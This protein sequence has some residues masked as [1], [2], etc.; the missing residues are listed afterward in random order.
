MSNQQ[1][2][3]ALVTGASRGIGAEI[4][5]RLAADGFAVAIN[6]ANSA[7][8]ANKLVSELQ[9]AGARAVAVQADMAQP[10][11]IRALFTQCE[12][13]LGALDVLVNNAGVMQTMPL[14]DT[15]DEL[16]AQTFAVNVQG[17]FA[18]LRE[19]A[20]RL[21]EGGRII[22]L[23]TSALAMKMPGY[24]IYNASK[25]AVEAMTQVFSKELRGRQITVNAVAPGPV[26]TE[27][28]LNGKTVEM[29]QRLAHMAPLER[30][31]QPEDIAAVVSFLASAEGGWINGQV[32]RANGGIA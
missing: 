28:F 2:K 17:V 12:Q 19:A 7:A 20:T 11:Q 24:A 13:Q 4:A 9:G 29:V 32:L 15:T 16:F 1:Q 22:N 18:C 23:S 3:V 30:L 27:L 25:A 5:R 10:E 31:G 26:E 6:Y 14:V 21:N 8:E